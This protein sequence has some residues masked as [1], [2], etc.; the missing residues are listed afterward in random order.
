M[1][2]TLV[3]GCDR[4]FA[5]PSSA[6]WLFLR[7]TCLLFDV[8]VFG[9]GGREIPGFGPAGVLGEDLAGVLGWP[10]GLTANEPAQRMGP[11]VSAGIAD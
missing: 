6:N 1:T 4:K 7:F 2:G 3:G 9:D 8:L 11:A 10:S 5:D